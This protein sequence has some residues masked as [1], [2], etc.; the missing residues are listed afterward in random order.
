MINKSARS[1]KER[2][3]EIL[4][5]VDNELPVPMRQS[6]YQMWELYGRLEDD[7]DAL[8]L[9]LKQL[10]DQDDECQRLVKL[11]GVGPITAVRLKLQLLEKLEK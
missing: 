11:E 7:F 3:P 1:F 6:L 5:D 10:T 8:D 9:R 4:E 2:L